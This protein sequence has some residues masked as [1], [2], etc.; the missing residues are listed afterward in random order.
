MNSSKRAIL[1]ISFGILILVSGFILL[2]NADFWT[3]TNSEGV[4]LSPY[5]VECTD[6]ARLLMC[7][8]AVLSV[9]SAVV[10]I[11]CPAPRIES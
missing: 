11:W 7:S 8:G 10:W 2:C 4:A 1:C 3:I 6:L 9:L 5:T